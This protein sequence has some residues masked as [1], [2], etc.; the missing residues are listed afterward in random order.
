[1]AVSTKNMNILQAGRSAGKSDN[2]PVPNSLSW[3]RAF[4]AGALHVWDGADFDSFGPMTGEDAGAI[5]CHEFLLAESANM[6][7]PEPADDETDETSADRLP[8]I[9]D[10]DDRGFPATSSWLRRLAK[11]AD[12][13]DDVAPPQWCLFP[14]VDELGLGDLLAEDSPEDDDEPGD[15]V[16]VVW[17]DGGLIEQ[18]IRLSIGTAPYPNVILSAA[19]ALVLQGHLAARKIED[20]TA[21]GPHFLALAIG[22]SASGKDHPRK[23][24]KACLEAIGDDESLYDG[25]ASHAAIEDKIAEKPELISTWD[26]FGCLLRAI[27]SDKSGAMEPTISALLRVTTHDPLIIRAKSGVDR[28][29]VKTPA[30]S[31]LATTTPD[32]FIEAMNVR[33]MRNGMMGRFGLFDAGRRG[34]GQDG[35]RPIPSPEM[36]ATMKAWHAWRPGGDLAI[37][38]PV[39]VVFRA[40]SY[41]KALRRK[42]RARADKAY[43]EFE[44]RNSSVGMAIMGRTAERAYR[45]ALLFAASRQGA[46]PRDPVI[47]GD[48]LARGEYLAFSMTD[49]LLQLSGD[50]GPENE[51]D[52]LAKR[53]LEFVAKEGKQ[54][55]QH[56]KALKA[57][58]VK[59]KEFRDVVQTLIERAQLRTEDREGTRFYVA[60]GPK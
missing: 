49:R 14:D 34:H 51:F 25:F 4:Y 23:C 35:R 10:D 6:R 42:I 56:S 60:I 11:W 46:N 50:I 16:P 17:R 57:S 28:K 55:V 33:L 58:K 19:G 29:S 45:I 38:N 36:V 12:G 27:A 48:D 47:T 53:V 31:I 20:E 3:R 18:F 40:T 7:D 39:P 32:E 44:S 2:L 13:S 21:L 41:A 52:K 15:P 43:R 9:D 30:L 54:G 24:I 8:C 22:H 37:I 1:M 59:T 5:A 26:E